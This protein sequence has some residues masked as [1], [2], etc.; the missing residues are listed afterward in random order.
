MS[1]S[2]PLLSWPGG[3][4]RRS[5]SCPAECRTVDRIDGQNMKVRI[6]DDASA[7]A[8]GADD[9]AAEFARA[10]AEV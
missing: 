8:C 1:L 3:D 9:V 2:G 10:G 7:L 5:S 6:F 4:D